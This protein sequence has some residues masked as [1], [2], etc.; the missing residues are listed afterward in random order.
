[1]SLVIQPYCSRTGTATTLSELRKRGWRLLVSATGVWR[2][3]GF[4]YALD[5]G[6]WTAHQKGLPMLDLDLFWSLVAKFGSGADWV[7]APDIVG[8][9]R[10][11]LELSVGN[12]PRLLDCAPKAALA[13]RTAWCR[14]KWCSTSGLG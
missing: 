11:S 10:A 4:G 6:A 12:L 3:E 7:V 14:R 8:G 13:C 2:T 1:M 9:G 5:N